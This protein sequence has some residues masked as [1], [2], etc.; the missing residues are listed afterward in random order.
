MHG[1]IHLSAGS[2]P[3]PLLFR[4]HGGILAVCD[5]NDRFRALSAFMVNNNR[6]SF[7][8]RTV[9]FMNLGVDTLSE[10]SLEDSGGLKCLRLG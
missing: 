1:R 4:A 3:F 10:I 5:C 8:I 2:P 9:N 7:A 6:K